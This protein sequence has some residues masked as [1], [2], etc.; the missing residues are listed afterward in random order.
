MRLDSSKQLPFTIFSFEVETMMA[1]R[2]AEGQ[3]LSMGPISDRDG[4]LRDAAVSM[5]K[6]SGY[7]PVAK[8]ACRVDQ[9]VIELAGVVPTFHMKQVAQAAVQRLEAIRGIRN[10]VQVA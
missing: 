10:R 2:T 6:S 3:Q 7:S 1:T 4:Y 5:L 9:G 8:L